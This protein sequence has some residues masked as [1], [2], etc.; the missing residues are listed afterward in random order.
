MYRLGHLVEEQWVEHSHPA[1]FR[2]NPSGS[3]TSRIT[4]GVQGSDPAVVLKLA[5]CLEEPLFL[6]YVLHT[7]RGEAEPARYQSPELALAEV[8]EFFEEFLPFLTGDG[9]FDLWLYSPSQRATVVWDRH[10]VLHGYGPIECYRAALEAAGFVEGELSALGVH[11]HHYRAE[12]D[13]YAKALISRY[14]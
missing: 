14:H 13:S 12:L 4:A 1:V 6:L 7:P 8:H 2:C 3:G 11:T 5:Q 9:R 10:N